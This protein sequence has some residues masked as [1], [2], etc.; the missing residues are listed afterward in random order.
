MGYLALP[1]AFHLEGY[2]RV[3]AIA[4]DF[5]VLDRGG[6]F[7]HENGADIAQGFRRFAHHVLGRFLPTARRFRHY[8][9]NFDDL[10]HDVDL[11]PLDIAPRAIGGL[12]HRSCRPKSPNERNDQAN[13]SAG[14]DH[15]DDAEFPAE[16]RDQGGDAERD[17]K[18]VEADLGMNDVEGEPDGEVEHDADDGGGHGGEGHGDS[19]VA[20][21]LLDVR[22]AEKDPKETGSEGDP[23][24]DERAEGRGPEGR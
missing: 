1:A 16:H 20:T 21:E 18:P 14:E 23:G 5:V 15:G 6:E 10:G 17:G 12:I 8:L 2:F 13:Y 3:Y 4:G 24:G 9:D 22:A 19:F 7:L 11:L